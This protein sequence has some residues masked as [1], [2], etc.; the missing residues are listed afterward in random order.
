M[1]PSDPS[2]DALAE[3]LPRARAVIDL[4]AV[5]ANTAR[6]AQAAPGAEVMAVVKADAYGHGLI[7]CARAA[8]EGGATWLGVALVEEAFALRAAGIDAPVLAWMIAPGDIDSRRRA[9]MLDIDL[10]ASDADGLAEAVA[11]ARRAQRPARV[12]LKVDT[13]MGR[14]GAAIADWAELA[15]LAAKAQESGDVVVT[16]VWSHLAYADVPHHP[17]IDAQLA[18]FRS[19]LAIADDAGL[20][21]EV[22]HLANSAA[23]LTRPETHFD[24]VRP[25][26]A[27]YG[28]SPG[29]EVGTATDLG[30]R[31]AMTLEATLMQVKRVPPGHGVSYGHDYVTTSETTL[32]LVPLGYAD[33]VPRAAG[34][35]GPVLAAGR[36]RH[37]AGRV[38]MD[39]FVLDVGDDPVRRGDPVVL[40]G[41][42]DRGEP[43]VEDWAQAADTIAYEIVT[44][45][46]PR[47][48]R[49]HVESGR[50]PVSRRA[51]V[52]PEARG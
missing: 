17:T 1:S 43:S 24:L 34:G 16:G 36:V 27:L 18:T 47:V 3:V 48:V 25:G 12:Q 31:P 28:I 40:F 7:P 33:G 52:S 45:I 32:G 38:C 4:A 44:R 11:A 41:P 46:G 14:A 22:R 50:G 13:G 2:A 37:V 21:P 42:G 10:A 5:R 26:I 9:I 8:L 15:A 35:L 6:L 30:L 20:D 23:T 51:E 49:E 39:Q 19:A 29:R